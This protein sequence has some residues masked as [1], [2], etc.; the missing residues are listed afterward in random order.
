MYVQVCA[1]VTSS[2]SPAMFTKMRTD[3]ALS[4]AAAAAAAAGVC[5]C[6]KAPQPGKVYEDACHSCQ[7]PCK[8]SGKCTGNFP[9]WAACQTPI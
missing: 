1:A 2:P 6:N 5:C 3:V 4:A 9:P 8:G 7:E